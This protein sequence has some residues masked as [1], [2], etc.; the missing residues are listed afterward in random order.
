M[1]IPLLRAQVLSGR[2]LLSNCPFFHSLPYRTDLVKVKV[3]V[4]VT[5]RLAVYCQSVRL[6]AK[7][8]VTHDERFLPTEPLR[9]ELFPSSGRL[10]LYIKNMRPISECFFHVCFAVAA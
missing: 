3:K 5:L 6:G 2:R 10:F 8:L 4:K 9:P 7:P 1:A